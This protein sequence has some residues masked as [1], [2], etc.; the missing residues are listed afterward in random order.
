MYRFACVYILYD[1][2]DSEEFEEA[3]LNVQLDNESETLLFL[4]IRHALIILMK[5]REI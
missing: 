4:L 3:L 1:T 2:E 5:S